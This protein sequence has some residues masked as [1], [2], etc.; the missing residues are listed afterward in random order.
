MAAETNPLLGY[1][2]CLDA[3]GRGDL[4]PKAKNTALALREEARA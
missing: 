2:R 3:K 4:R 1:G